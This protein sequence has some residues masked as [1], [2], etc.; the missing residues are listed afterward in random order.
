MTRITTNI[1]GFEIRSTTPADAA[2]ILSLIRELAEYERLTDEVVATEASL[3]ESLFG[4]RP[5]AEV[6]IGEFDGAPVGYALYFHNYSTFVGRAGMYLEDIYVRPESRGR[7]FG[8]ALLLHVARQAK[9]RGC[10]RL[11]WAVLDWN[12][13][14]IAFYESL[15]AVAMDEWT[16]FRVTGEALNALA[17]ED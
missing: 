16:V 6:V 1:R 3:R 12:T 10:R 9:A 8:K 15:G 7:G 4:D 13:P 17:E 14:A 2:L 11:E 5:T